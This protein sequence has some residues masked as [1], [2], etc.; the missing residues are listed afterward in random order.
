MAEVEVP[1]GYVPQYAMAFGAVDAPA[2]AVHDDNPLPVRAVRKPAASIPLTGTLAASGL[3]GP[4]VPELERSI[5]LT[6]TGDWSG[7]VELLRS[8]DGAATAL[9]LTAGGARWGRFTAN[10]NEVVADEG[11]AGAR[12]YLSATL[13]GG[14]LAYR[15]A[16]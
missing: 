15:V 4:F 10:A 14:T 12:Y 11:E 9:P 5:R 13:F 16:Q 7:T 2:V 1:A 6:L 3:A 8:A